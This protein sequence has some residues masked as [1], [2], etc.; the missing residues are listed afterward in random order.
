MMGIKISINLRS[1][2]IIPHWPLALHIRYEFKLRTHPRC[3][4]KNLIIN[5]LDKGSKDILYTAY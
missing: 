3:L 4:A 5:H 1:P 2:Q